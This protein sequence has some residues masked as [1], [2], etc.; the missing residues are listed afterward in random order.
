MFFKFNLNK[1]GPIGLYKLILILSAPVALAKAVI[2]GIHLIT[3]AQNMGNIDV[4]D[5]EKLKT[6]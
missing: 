4:E 3:A 1:V 5:R 6:K 2:S